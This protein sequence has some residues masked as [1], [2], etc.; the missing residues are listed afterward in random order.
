MT[1]WRAIVAFLVALA[2]CGAVPAEAKAQHHFSHRWPKAAKKEDGVAIN[3][4][5]G[6]EAAW[7][8]GIKNSLA[9]AL[10]AASSKLLLA[11]L[12]T[13]KTLQQSQRASGE[14]VLSVMEAAKFI[15]QRPKGFLELYVSIFNLNDCCV[16]VT[17][18]IFSGGDWGCNVWRHAVGRLVF[19][20]LLVLQEDF[21][22]I[23]PRCFASPSNSIYRL[24]GGHREYCCI[25]IPRSL[26]GHETE[27]TD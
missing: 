22:R 18:R 9:S 14:A 10:A 1:R 2:T 4:F 3:S 21:Q 8:S 23:G 15:M 27:F 16:Q 13:I 24:I 26:R 25:R 20:N 12:D 17:K 11:P 5:R 6:G 19:W 7:R